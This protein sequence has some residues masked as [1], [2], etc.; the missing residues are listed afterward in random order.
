M[1]FSFSPW[2]F[3]VEFLPLIF[4][5]RK[6]PIIAILA[7]KRNIWA[8]TEG[9]KSALYFGYYLICATNFHNWRGRQVVEQSPFW[10][11]GFFNQCFWTLAKR[12][13]FAHWCKQLLMRSEI[14]SRLS[15][16]NI[17]WKGGSSAISGYKYLRIFQMAAVCKKGN[18]SDVKAPFLAFTHHFL[19][20]NSCTRSLDK[21]SPP[22]FLPLSRK[23]FFGFSF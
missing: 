22:Y 11:A 8:R 17:L 21:V 14:W 23:I 4:P 18:F 1:H 15:M 13:F 20:F 6:P 10:K 3:S 12:Y 7:S 2:W 9:T 16:C 19:K 5:S